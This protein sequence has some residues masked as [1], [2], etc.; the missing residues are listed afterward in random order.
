MYTKKVLI[1]VKSVVNI[2]IQKGSITTRP[3]RFG[4][5]R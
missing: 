2:V 4:L 3:G 5:D 1:K